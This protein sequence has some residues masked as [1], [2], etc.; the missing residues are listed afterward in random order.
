MCNLLQIKSAIGKLE[1]QKHDL[2]GESA[3]I[4]D[5]DIKNNASFCRAVRPRLIASNASHYEGPSGRQQLLRDLA[6]LK[7]AMNGKIPSQDT[8]DVTEFPRLIAMGR[9]QSGQL[10]SNN[11]AGVTANTAGNQN[12]QQPTNIPQVAA[13]GHG[14]LQVPG[15]PTPYYADY[16]QR[17]N[18]YH[19]GY[20]G[21]QY[22]YSPDMY[23]PSA[24]YYHSYHAADNYYE[25]DYSTSQDTIK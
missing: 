7:I 18:L 2:K 4:K 21:Y 16:Y 11:D 23:Y 24:D 3:A 15:T 14:G 19:Y 8:N 17:P 13:T 5:F 9:K 22:P 6:L 1:K 12:I 10:N 25:G 20:P